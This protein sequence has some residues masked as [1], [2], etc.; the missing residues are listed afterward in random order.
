MNSNPVINLIEKNFENISYPK[1]QIIRGEYLYGKSKK[2]VA[3]NY[4]DYSQRVLSEDFNLDEYQDELIAKDYYT[5]VGYSQWSFYLYFICA[6]DKVDNILKER[7]ENDDKYTRK[8]LITFEYLKQVLDTRFDFSIDLDTAIREDI[9]ITWIKKLKEKNLD[10][11]FLDAPYIEVVRKYIEGD[12]IKEKEKGVETSI[13]SED[14]LRFISKLKL[15][16]FRPYP[17]GNEFVFEKVNLIKGING[18]GK[19]SLLEAIE[20]CLCGKTLRNDDKDRFSKISLIYEDGRQD[21]LQENNRKFQNRDLF[22]YGNSYPRGNYLP[23]SFNKYNFYNSDTA[24]MLAKENDPI[25]IRKAFL[26]LALGENANYIDERLTKI[27]DRFKESAKEYEREFERLLALKKSQEK[28][29]QNILE[30]KDNSLAY[31]EAFLSSA[32]KINWLGY[33]PK[34]YEDSRVQFENQFSSLEIYIKEIQS[35]LNWLSLISFAA[36]ESEAKKN[37]LIS[38]R[39]NKL[40]LEISNKKEVAEKM[41]ISLNSLVSTQTLFAKIYPYLNEKQIDL[42]DGLQVKLDKLSKEREKFRLVMQKSKDINFSVF[43]EER[44]TLVKYEESQRR[45]YKNLEKELKEIAGKI[46]GVKLTFSKLEGIVK[47]IKL[48]GLDFLSTD[49][50]ATNCPLCNAKYEAGELR[51]KIKDSQ[52]ELKNTKVLEGLLNKH[53]EINEEIAKININLRFIEQIKEIAAILSD[54]IDYSETYFE[55]LIKRIS[56]ISESLLSIEKELSKLSILKNK[57]MANGL[58]EQVFIKLKEEA[59][60]KALNM[61]LSYGN[62]EKINRLVNEIEVEIKSK[63]EEFKNNNQLLQQLVKERDELFSDYFN[64]IEYKDSLPLELAKRKENLKQALDYYNKLSNAVAITHYENIDQTLVALQELKN[65]FDNFKNAATERKENITI[66]KECKKNI[67][68][69]DRNLKILEP[70]RNSSAVAIESIEDIIENYNKEKYFESFF[71]ENKDFIVNIF[72]NIHSPLEFFSIDLAESGDSGEILL[73]RGE[74]KEPTPL[75][76]ISSGQ[77]S[78]LFISI[79]LSLNRQLKSGPPFMIFDDPVAHV[80]DMNILSFLD[81]L[82]DI[83]ISGNKQIFFATASQKITNLFQKK[84]EFL[85]GDFKIIELDR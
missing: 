24:Y 57:F 82:R 22:W 85:D 35:K 77:R 72:R 65:V 28:T 79:F 31:F 41:E 10:G 78:A 33:L 36:V 38:N 44:T 47:E 58:D 69:F 83:A 76:Q 9:S 67:E 30:T 20:L 70:K 16:Y 3:I 25:K 23:L 17:K 12:P 8:R 48:K 13:N 74:E 81:Y 7:I 64:N 40:T 26:S 42:L 61:T 18:S 34:T 50:K 71:K 75:S 62:R 46:E 49:P 59:S 32:K 73:G 55:D 45:L 51:N 4:F 19:T 27:L 43:K 21:E 5:H 60:Q 29:L 52:K 80:D 84:F 2:L 53:K 54:S 68:Q 11:V 39:A 6:Q 66:V 1:D 56:N 14:K 63:K 15:E 37:D